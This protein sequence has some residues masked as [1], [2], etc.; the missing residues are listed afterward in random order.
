MTSLSGAPSGSQLELKFTYDYMGRRI[1]KI[2]STNNGSSYVGEYTNNYGYDGWNC[3]ATMS[4]TFALSNTFMWGTD[5]SGRMQGAGGVG[6]M[7][8]WHITEHPQRIVL[9]R[10]M[11]TGM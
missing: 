1:Q 10:M 6:G 9:W 3:M 11:A 8:K 7:S 4:P 2:V 5:I